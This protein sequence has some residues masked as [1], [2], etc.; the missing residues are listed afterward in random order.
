MDIVMPK[1]MDLLTNRKPKP[2][3]DL[4]SKA[5]QPFY[6]GFTVDTV[7]STMMPRDQ[8]VQVFKAEPMVRKVITKVNR[9]IFHEGWTIK[10]I[11]E[12]HPADQKILDVCLD[13]D[14][15]ARTKQTLELAG[16]S[17]CVYGDGFLEEMFLGEGDDVPSSMPPAAGLE[18]AKLGILD[19]AYIMEAAKQTEADPTVY[20]IYQKSTERQYWHP[21]R[22]IHVV[23]NIIPG[24]MFGYSIIMCGGKILQSKLTADES[25]GKF[26]EWAGAGVIQGSYDGATSN[27]ILELEK[28]L[29]HRKE[30]IWTD[31]K[32]KM[33]VLNP[34][35]MNPEQYNDYFFINIAAL[36][37]MPQHLL[38]G[39][40]PGQLTGSEMGLADYYKN[41]TDLQEQVFTPVLERIYTDLLRGHG[42]TFDGLEISWNPIYIDEG[43]ESAILLQRAQAGALLLDRGAI[44]SD[45]YR[46]ICQD[47]IEKL[48]GDAVLDLPAPPP[49]PVVVQ[50]AAGTPGQKVT[51]RPAVSQQDLEQVRIE[52]E[53]G[54][55]EEL[56]QELRVKEAEAKK[57]KS[58][59]GKQPVDVG[60]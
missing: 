13:F 55:I 28:R 37:I 14:R 40:Q 24:R 22:V 6:M 54:R 39:V 10:A 20:Y 34:T 44:T 38:T 45:E 7:D 60:S 1:W 48:T 58:R 47:G 26:I 30:I 8:L 51:E 17:S 33:Q 5:A 31:E 21:G 9:D 50:P 23:E 49:K 12:K 52:R 15:R 56:E 36:G 43:S 35:T 57:R 2:T 41:I 46:T 18:L 53:R 42:L 16:I 59:T 19:A 25:Y 27:D 32:T 4:Q 29:P 3:S 11:D